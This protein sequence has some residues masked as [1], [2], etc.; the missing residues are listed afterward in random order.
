MRCVAPPGQKPAKLRGL[1]LSKAL[2]GS[3]SPAAICANLSLKVAPDG[4]NFSWL[5]RD[6]NP[7]RITSIKSGCSS[8]PAWCWAALNL[9]F[10]PKSEA[11]C[12]LWFPQR[13]VAWW[14]LSTE[15]AAPLLCVRGHPKPEQTPP[16][17]SSNSSSQLWPQ[18]LSRPELASQNDV[19][20]AHRKPIGMQDPK[21]AASFS[22]RRGACLICC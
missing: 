20:S 15:L 13:P 4:H 17:L 14:G 8:F 12:S 6:W 19:M 2:V 21:L 16:L 22:A 10:G 5:F 3:F 7:R 1:A 18:K 11:E 9:V